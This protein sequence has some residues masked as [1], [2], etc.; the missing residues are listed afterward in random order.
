MGGLAQRKASGIAWSVCGKGVGV[1]VVSAARV[2]GEV[3]I[4]NSFG[5]SKCRSGTWMVTSTCWGAKG[6]EVGCV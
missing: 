4:D 5:A 6:W 1:I 2:V 3:E